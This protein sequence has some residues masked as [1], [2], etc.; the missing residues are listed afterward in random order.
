MIIH[1]NNNIYICKTYASKLLYIIC[2]ISPTS[3]PK[4]VKG[5]ISKKRT[6]I[7]VSHRIGAVRT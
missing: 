4:S 6:H 5:N 3:L 7:V 2:I 1:V